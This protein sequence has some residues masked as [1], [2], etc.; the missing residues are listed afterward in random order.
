MKPLVVG[1]LCKLIHNTFLWKESSTARRG[2]LNCNDVVLV[3]NMQHDS[4]LNVV[5][6]SR[7]GVGVVYDKLLDA[8]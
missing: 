2:C 4:Y 1:Q 8:L 5:V 3:L 6:L 7:I